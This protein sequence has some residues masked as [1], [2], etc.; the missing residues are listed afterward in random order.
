[1]NGPYASPAKIAIALTALETTAIGTDDTIL[2][3]QA[4]V[5]AA[6]LMS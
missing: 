4:V 6:N 5:L 1:M 2:L 3:Q